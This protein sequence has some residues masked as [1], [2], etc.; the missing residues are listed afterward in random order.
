[1]QKSPNYLKRS[2]SFLN[3][4]IDT[5]QKFVKTGKTD[6]VNSGPNVHSLMDTLNSEQIRTRKQT[7]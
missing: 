5:K 7:K 6:I 4:P 1:M 3:K 2:Q